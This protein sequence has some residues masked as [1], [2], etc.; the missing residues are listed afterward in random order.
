[1]YVTLL[2]HKE[3][4]KSE[5]CILKRQNLWPLIY[6][7]SRQDR[8]VT[9]INLSLLVIEIRSQLEKVLAFI[10]YVVLFE[11]LLKKYKR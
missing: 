4:E 11:K 1:M 7:N 9:A 8:P 5:K 10:S 2:R 3:G 6:P